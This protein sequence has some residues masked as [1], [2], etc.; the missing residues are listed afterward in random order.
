MQYGEEKKIMEEKTRAKER[1]LYV[2]K[3]L[4]QNTDEDHPLSTNEILAKLFQ[5]YGI[6][7]HRTTL[8]KDVEALK[9]FGLDVV[10]LHSTQSKFFIGERVFELPELKLLIDA[11]ESSKFITSRKTRSLISKIYRLTSVGQAELLRQNVSIAENRIKPDNEQIY[12][13]VDAINEAIHQNRQISFLYYEYNAD[14]KKVLKNNGEP[15]VLSPYHLVWSGDYYYLIGYSERR[16]K[17]VTFRV[18]RIA[19]VPEL[20]KKTALPKPPGYDLTEFIKEVFQMYGGES[21][22][23]ELQCKNE[24]M[25][26]MIDRFGESVTTLP[27]DKDSFRLIAEVA[28]SPTFFGWVFSFGGDVKILSPKILI[29]QYKEKVR[30]AASQFE[31]E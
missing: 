13:I 10:T 20:T 27:C 25:K 26:V 2:M 28:A 12:Y 9:A 7:A 21:T 6:T 1:I 22:A 16:G 17:V 3:I 31:A 29:D 30:Q 11:V 19:K 14:K 8:A 15:Y 23:V 24:L 18:D 4:L 5:D